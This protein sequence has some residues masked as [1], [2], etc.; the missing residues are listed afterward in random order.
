VWSQ[1]G[2]GTTAIALDNMLL[3]TGGVDGMVSLWNCGK[4][5]LQ[6]SFKTSAGRTVLALKFAFLKPTKQQLL[7][8]SIT[9]MLYHI[10]T[11]RMYVKLS[12]TLGTC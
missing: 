8:V 9:A 11:N 3:A 10:H 5:T 1:E 4:W 6:Q 2:Q 7:M 12:F